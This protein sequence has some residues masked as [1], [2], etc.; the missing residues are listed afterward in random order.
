VL[1]FLLAKND[2]FL[3]KGACLYGGMYIL[4]ILQ[5]KAQH[6]HQQQKGCPLPH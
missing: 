3:E 5:K 1:L 6:Q 2:L 4:K